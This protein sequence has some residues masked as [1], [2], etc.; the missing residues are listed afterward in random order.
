MEKCG[1]FGVIPDG[2]FS[3]EWAIK[4]FVTEVHLH[5]VTACIA[6]LFYIRL[7]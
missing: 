5:K 2:A 1:V 6:I 4:Y 7:H 3:T